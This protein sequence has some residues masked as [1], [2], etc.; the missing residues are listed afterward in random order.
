MLHQSLQPLQQ[1]RQWMLFRLVPGKNG[2][3]DKLPV[4]PNTLAVVSAHDPA[5]WT[6]YDAAFAALQGLSPEDH[7]LAFVFTA[8]DPFFFLD[9]DHCLENGQ[10]SQTALQLGSLMQGCAVEI[11]SS[12]EGL[13]I[14]GMYDGAEPSHRKKN[15]DYGIELYTSGRFVALTNNILVPGGS[16]AF[17]AGS[18]LQAL[19][20]TFFHEDA[21]GP[22]EDWRDRPVPEWSGPTDDDLLIAKM[23]ASRP[24]AAGVFGGKATV[25]DLWHGNEAALAQTYPTQN[26]VDPYDR[27]SADAALAQHLA[28][29]TGKDHERM[30]RLMQHSALVREKW[31]G[32][33][34]YLPMTISN[35]VSKQQAVYSS[36][37]APERA[38][39]PVSAPAQGPTIQPVDRESIFP[40]LLPAQMKELFAG[41]VYIRSLNRILLPTG[42]LF[43]ESQFKNAFGGNIYQAFFEGGTTKN[44]WEAFT[45][46]HLISFPQAHRLDFRPDRPGEPLVYEDDLVIA[47][48]Y[49][50]LVTPRKPGDVSPFLDFLERLLPDE[51]DRRILLS[52]M[53]AVIQYIG[54]KFQWCP[55]LQGAE[56]NG[57]SFIIRILQAAVGSRYTHVV[58][59]RGVSNNFNAWLENKLF[60]AIEE[61]FAG[62]D[63]KEI[64]EDLKA[65]IS[66]EEAEIE[67]KGQ[68]QYMGHN[69]ANIVMCTNHRSAVLVTA[70]TRR[71][72]VFYTAQQTKADLDR[73]G[74]G[75][76][77]WPELYRW[78]RSGGYAVI[79]DF[80]LNYQID[81]EFNPAGMC[82]RAPQTST[83]AEAI[84]ET[85]DPQHAFV[86]E[87]IDSGM[88]GLNG[89]WV[90]STLLAGHLRAE[91]N[92]RLA[93]KTLAAALTHLGYIHHPA[94]PAGRST[95]NIPHE[96]MRRGR[97]WV[98][99]GHVSSNIVDPAQAVQA[100]M[101]AQGYAEGV[102]PGPHQENYA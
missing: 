30:L 69:F 92:L 83:Q 88:Q 13:H 19:I 59:S 38:P 94:L 6:S 54:V 61:I 68:D 7:G 16:S 67:R 60:V 62:H 2:K 79:T 95:V 72:A 10:W 89:G 22:T 37:P 35:A 90:N 47:N 46:N 66:N 55:V 17:V 41:M 102:S 96:K 57:K 78:A 50:P 28:F 26:G 84:E 101:K 33:Q 81:E 43:N 36:S 45:S 74:M 14:F 27:S 86:R 29:W 51:R 1:W 99:Q 15:A 34:Q 70:D 24:S 21:G 3:K 49:V 25:A 98:K 76:N 12:G 32:H 75:G 40:L 44:A 42:E 82:Q 97:L 53:A 73:T 64:M 5:G 87:A 48:T 63:R 9:I 71:Y 91:Y 11:S 18:Q 31:T 85:L 8:Q 80:L 56:G 77:Y 58:K 39:A 4:S 100:Y 20:D 23:L 65:L 93:P 52:F